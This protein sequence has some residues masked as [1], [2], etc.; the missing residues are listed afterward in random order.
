MLAKQQ[1]ELIKVKAAQWLPELR[2][3]YAHT[4]KV[5]ADDLRPM[6]C[7]GFIFNAFLYFPF[8]FKLPTFFGIFLFLNYPL[9]P[10]NLI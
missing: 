6:T 2:T 1:E 5:S 9:Q 10:T 3:S 7:L 4:L 8:V